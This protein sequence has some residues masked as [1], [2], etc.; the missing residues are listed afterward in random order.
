MEQQPTRSA[1]QLS[2]PSRMVES[3]DE[4]HH[5]EEEEDSI[6]GPCD[7]NQPEFTREQERMIIEGDIV[8]PIKPMPVRAT[9]QT[10]PTSLTDL[11]L[12]PIESWYEVYKDDDEYL[13]YWAG[14]KAQSARDREVEE[15]HRRLETPSEQSSFERYVPKGEADNA[16]RRAAQS[17]MYSREYM[18]SGDATPHKA[19]KT[20]P[21]KTL[22]RI[23]SHLFYL[24]FCHYA[25]IK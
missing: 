5:S 11:N 25:E 18:I 23:L 3:S 12:P 15:E 7:N 2:T 14:H 16:T 20:P 4:S 9:E 8:S 6:L 22:N 10:Q 17:N 19:I 24:K 13:K 21:N 1:L